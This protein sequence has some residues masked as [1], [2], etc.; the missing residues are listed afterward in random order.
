MYFID[1]VYDNYYISAAKIICMVILPKI[2]LD[3]ADIVTSSSIVR[4]LKQG[5]SA[6]QPTLPHHYPTCS[7]SSLLLQFAF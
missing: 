6:Y 1:V 4:C 2:S 7:R 3:L 5:Y